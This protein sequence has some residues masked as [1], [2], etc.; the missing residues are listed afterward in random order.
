MLEEKPQTQGRGHQMLEETIEEGVKTTRLEE[1]NI[2]P[3]S[4]KPPIFNIATTIKCGDETMMYGQALEWNTLNYT[5]I[6]ILILYRLKCLATKN[7][8]KFQS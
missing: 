4:Y 6:I 3:T 7:K 1:Q 2:Q 8:L 5:K